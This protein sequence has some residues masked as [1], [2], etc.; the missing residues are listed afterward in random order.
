MVTDTD[1]PCSTLLGHNKA[2]VSSVWDQVACKFCVRCRKGQ[3]L[4]WHTSVHCLHATFMHV[5]RDILR[6]LK[7]NI[8]IGGLPCL[9]QDINLLE[10]LLE[11]EIHVYHG[12]L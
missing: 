12:F 6:P 1:F 9:G 4:D 3:I 5:G 11:L 8:F 2:H 10:L 7:G